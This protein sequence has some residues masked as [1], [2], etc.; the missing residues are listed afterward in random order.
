MLKE[1]Y[2]KDKI[3]TIFIYPDSEVELNVPLGDY[4]LFYATGKDWY[5]TEYL[6]GPVTSYFK[7]DEKLTF[8]ISGDYVMGVSIELIKQSGGN[9]PTQDISKGDFFD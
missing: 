8:Y 2:S 9:M 4:L 5:G 1:Y 6:F 3:L 7:S